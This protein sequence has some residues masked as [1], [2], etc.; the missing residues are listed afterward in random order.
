M[1]TGWSVYITVLALANI[2][3]CLW[4]LWW[5]SRRR[6][7]EIAGETTGHTWD[8]DLRELNNPLP[9][10]WLVLFYLT[11]FFALGYLVLYPGLGSY[12]GTLGWTQEKRYETESAAVD[13][14]QREA[15]AKFDGLELAALAVNDE[16]RGIGSRLFANNC[17]VCHGADGHGA[18][19]FPDLSDGD[20]LYGDNA[21]QIIASITHG[22]AGVMPP[23]GAALGERGVTEV[24]AWVYQRN[25]RA[26]QPGTVSMLAAGEQKFGMFCAACH[27]Q[28]ATGNTAMGA[29]N[30]A[31]E[32]WL[33]GGSFDAI[34][35]TVTEGRSG[36]MPAHEKLLNAD[37]IRLLAAYVQGLSLQGS[38]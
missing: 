9:R 17:A 23:M 5:T 32:T 37:E 31:D 30:L 24:A 36:R 14:M 34:R 22:R 3:G 19:G 8:S 2:L 4:L 12:A 7:D 6:P 16:A 13:A 38:H 28:D 25:G 35:K 33:Y 20:W 27:G 21:T 10:W 29:P 1:T 26:A 18:P 11:V 15:F